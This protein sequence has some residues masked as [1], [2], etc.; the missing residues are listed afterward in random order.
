M[1]GGINEMTNTSFSASVF[2]AY[3]GFTVYW[4]NGGGQGLDG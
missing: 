4:M 2:L 3:L 1:D